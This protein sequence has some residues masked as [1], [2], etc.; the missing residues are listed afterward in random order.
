VPCHATGSRFGGVGFS[1]SVGEVGV[2]VLGP[3]LSRK[4]EVNGM[5]SLKLGQLPK[6]QDGCAVLAGPMDG[7]GTGG[8]GENV[9]H[10]S[11]RK[12]L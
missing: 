2:P 7:A 11:V 5:A 8:E 4:E 3:I 10:W 12:G 9:G 1:A 6:R